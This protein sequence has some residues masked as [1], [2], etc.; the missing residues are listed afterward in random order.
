MADASANAEVAAAGESL[1]LQL[2]WL[3]L[4][5]TSSAALDCTPGLKRRSAT[6]TSTPIDSWSITRSED[7][8]LVAL[9]AEPPKAGVAQCIHESTPTPTSSAAATRDVC[10]SRHDLCPGTTD[11]PAA[12]LA[13]PISSCLS[14]AA[15]GAST[16][17]VHRAAETQ[18][19]TK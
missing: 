16:C 4:S 14:A 13:G 10:T 8:L 6:C 17:S 1:D 18:R 3:L 11:S 9:L 5:E 15:N 7:A 2:H 19:H 12:L